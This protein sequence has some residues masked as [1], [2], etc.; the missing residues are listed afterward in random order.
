[1]GQQGSRRDDGERSERHTYPQV[2][3]L[4]KSPI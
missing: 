2:S 1:L 4:D 3:H